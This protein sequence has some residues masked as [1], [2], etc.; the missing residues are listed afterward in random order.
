MYKSFSRVYD[1]DDEGTTGMKANRM[2]PCKGVSGFNATVIVAS[3]WN[4]VVAEL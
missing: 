2:G 1:P 4:L 3:I